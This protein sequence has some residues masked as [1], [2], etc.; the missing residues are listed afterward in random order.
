MASR[1]SVRS[2]FP[3]GSR[4]RASRPSGHKPSQHHLPTYFQYPTRKS[5]IM[6]YNCS[7]QTSMIYTVQPHAVQSSKQDCVIAPHEQKK[8]SPCPPEQWSCPS[9]IFQGDQHLTKPQLADA[10]DA[11]L[12]VHWSQMAVTFL[13]AGQLLSRESYSLKR[14]K[15]EPRAEKTPCQRTAQLGR[16]S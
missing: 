5:F 16:L 1:Y 10:T 11:G 12:R 3:Q 14:Q 4:T 7:T 9:D 13:V 2:A 8:K 6:S 15:K